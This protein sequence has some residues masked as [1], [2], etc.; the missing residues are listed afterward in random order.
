MI[1]TGKQL[2]SARELI[3]ISQL[4]LAVHFQIGV[5]RVIAF[6]AGEPTIPNEILV[7]LR[8][9]LEAAGVEFFMNDVRLKVQNREND[10]LKN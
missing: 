2:V 1:I 4:A 7:H 5:R 9:A 8:A 6:E 3:G 10:R